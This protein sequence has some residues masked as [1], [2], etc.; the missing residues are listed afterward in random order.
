MKKVLVVFILAVLIFATP[1]MAESPMKK[2][3]EKIKIWFTFRPE[4]KAERFL[5]SAESRLNE[6]NKT[7]VEGNIKNIEKMQKDYE[8]AINE[9]EKIINNT[10]FRGNRTLLA[11][12]IC[13]MT[14]KNII[15][16]QR[17]LEKAP[18]Q[19]KPA[20][21]HAI[22]ISLKRHE[23]CTERLL[24]TWNKTIE[25]IQMINCTVDADC[26]NITCPQIIGMD[27][28]LCEY[29]KC[30]CGNKW[31]IFNKTEWEERFKEKLRMCENDDDCII[32][33]CNNELC[34]PKSIV[35]YTVS[36]CLW[37]GEYKCLEFESC[38]CDDNICRWDRGDEYRECIR[39][40]TKPN[41][42][43]PN[44]TWPNVTKSNVTRPNIT[45]PN[46]TKPN[47]TVRMNNTCTSDD[48]C[49]WCGMMCI[50]KQQNIACM[51]IAPLKNRSCI[52]KDGRCMTSPSNMTWPNI[53]AH[54]M[55]R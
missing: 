5:N 1:V 33:G 39:N 23:N 29:G 37:K 55:T 4:A 35:N 6:L 53:T 10:G 41:I 31:E 8:S 36:I 22:N 34:L 40:L 13:N 2:I 51:E 52:C 38:K 15:I 18:E 48:D 14:Y 49:Q 24:E 44:I 43:W 12:Y 21:S 30:K 3:Y 28:T 27:T 25:K 26:M 54:N 19:A 11:E 45:W 7:M 16:L 20:I 50:K 46:I 42:T 17:I 9:T 32:A 47:I